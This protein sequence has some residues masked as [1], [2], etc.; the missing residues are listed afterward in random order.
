MVQIRAKRKGNCVSLRSEGYVV[1]VDDHA[2]LRNIEYWL[3]LDFIEELVQSVAHG[4]VL[5]LLLLEG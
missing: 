3:H 4:K 2:V 1:Q 5:P